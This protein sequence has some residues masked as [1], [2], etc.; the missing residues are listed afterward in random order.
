MDDIDGTRYL[1]H[2]FYAGR[3]GNDTTILAQL[4]AGDSPNEWQFIFRTRVD[5]GTGDP[6]DGADEKRHWKATFKGTEDVAIERA[7]KCVTGAAQ[8]IDIDVEVIPIRSSDRGAV[9]DALKGKPWAY[10]KVEEQ[11]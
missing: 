11:Q 8:L 7:M 6:F 3:A 5:A 2:I 4:V 1:S 9:I 10:F